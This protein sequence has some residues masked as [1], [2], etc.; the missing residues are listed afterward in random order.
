MAAD[1]PDASA[2][3]ELHEGWEELV[4]ARPGRRNALI[5]PMVAQLRAGLA[6]LLANGARVVLLRGEGGAF[7]SGLDVD[8]SPRG[9]PG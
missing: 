9:R 7:C 3:A 5:G 6:E 8:A 4:L 1:E 2:R